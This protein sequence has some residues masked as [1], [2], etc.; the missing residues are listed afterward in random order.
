MYLMSDKLSGENSLSP[1][2]I[3]YFAGLNSSIFVNVDFGFIDSESIGSVGGSANSDLVLYELPYRDNPISSSANAMGTTP[4]SIYCE[5]TMT[6]PVEFNIVLH[7]EL[8]FPLY[9]E[10]LEGLKIRPYF[11]SAFGLYSKLYRLLSV[12]L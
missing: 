8:I 9:F 10:I 4:P 11:S 3:T 5:Y 7:I 12:V 1:V 2:I 6:M